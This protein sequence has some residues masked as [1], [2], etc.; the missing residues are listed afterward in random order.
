MNPELAVF[1]LEPLPDHLRGDPVPLSAVVGL[2]KD[3]L[4]QD[5][6]KI[7]DQIRPVAE[8]LRQDTMHDKKRRRLAT[9]QRIAVVVKRLDV[10]SL[11]LLG[12]LQNE[13]MARENVGHLLNNLGV[14]GVKS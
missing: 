9:V 1:I 5:L 7:G 4:T 10:E 2:S 14:A 12:Q 8:M 11:V 13:C 3:I 6:A